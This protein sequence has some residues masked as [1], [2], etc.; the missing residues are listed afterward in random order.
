[1]PATVPGAY[2]AFARGMALSRAEGIVQRDFCDIPGADLTVHLAAG[3]N[4][5]PSGGYLTYEIKASNAAA[6]P[7]RER[8]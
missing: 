6:T 1:M 7:R 3:P 8:R 5:V 2:P 4:P